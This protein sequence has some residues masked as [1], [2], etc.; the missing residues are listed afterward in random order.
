[1]RIGEAA[2]R[3]GVSCDTLRYYERQG[4]LPRPP[5]TPGGYRDYTESAINRVRFVRNALRFGFAVKQVSAF[6][7]SRD[8]GKPPCRE[9]RAAAERILDEMDRRIAELT[10]ARADVHRMLAVWDE[11]LAATPAGTPARLLDTIV[12]SRG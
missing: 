11:R 3:A 1:M 9:V 12:D 5:R 7:K 6:V 4:L 8:S 10:A 2:A